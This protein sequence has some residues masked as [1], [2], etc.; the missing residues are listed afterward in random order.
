MK[1][2]FSDLYEILIKSVP[3]LSFDGQSRLAVR[4]Q[5]EKCWLVEM[6]LLNKGNVTLTK[7]KS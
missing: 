7:V 3:L 2:D 5:Q 1:T 6:L 4:A